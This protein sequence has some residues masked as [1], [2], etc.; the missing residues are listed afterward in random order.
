MNKKIIYILTIGITLACQA[1]QPVISLNNRPLFDVNN[2]YYKDT[3]GDFD[4]LI[5]VWSYQNEAEEFTITLNKKNQYYNS[6][7]SKNIAYYYDLLYGEYKYVDPT[8]N[9]VVNTLNLM[10]SYSD[11]YDYSITGNDILAPYH[12]PVC[13]DCGQNERRVY[14][15]IEDT[16]RSYFTYRL[17]IRH[18]AGSAFNNQPEKIIIKIYDGDMTIVPQGLPTDTRLPLFEEF[19]LIKQ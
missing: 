7:D 6:F 5:G 19:T 14:L 17:S 11:V 3:Q 2:A 13:D 16:E 10:E 4:E 1:Q 15:F 8:G 12:K 9:E 18:I